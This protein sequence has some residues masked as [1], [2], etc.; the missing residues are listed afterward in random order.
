KIDTVA[1]LL[2]DELRKYPVQRLSLRI[3]SRSAEWPAVLE[4]GMR[5]LWGS[6]AVKV[7]EL[8]QLRRDDVD[9]A[10]RT[11][12]IT[13]SAAFLREVAEKN[14]GPLAAKPVT[15]QLLLNLWLKDQHLPETQ[16]ELYERGC[17]LLC[18][19]E[20]PGL[21]RTLSAAEKMVVASRIAAVTV[22]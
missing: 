1:T 3:A 19:E 10:A 8:I 22:F 4:D 15:L 21:R 2:I 16:A 5:E 18:E 17:R 14:A 7:Y 9:R 6:E 13:D 11:E 12:G 20:K